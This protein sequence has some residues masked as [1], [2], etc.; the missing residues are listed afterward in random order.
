MRHQKVDPAKAQAAA[1]AVRD[2]MSYRMA[3]FTYDVSKSSITRLN[4]GMGASVG[5]ATI[6]IQEED[7]QM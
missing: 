5:P 6:L 3:G 4:D 1:G 7:N 2:G